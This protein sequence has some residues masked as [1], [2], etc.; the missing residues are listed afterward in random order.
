MVGD[1]VGSKLGLA[2]GLAPDSCPKPRF[3]GP[4]DSGNPKSIRNGYG[5]GY[6]L[7]LC[8]NKI[9]SV[10]VISTIQPQFGLFLMV[11]YRKCGSL[12]TSWQCNNPS[13]RWISWIINEYWVPY[14]FQISPPFNFCLKVGGGENWMD[15][16]LALENKGE[17]RGE[18][19]FEGTN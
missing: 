8:P 15:E 10:H 13:S 5:T 17:G 16:K 9:M 2:L 14:S 6:E 4:T 11:T 3:L 7:A 18:Q 1:G 19:N 12:K